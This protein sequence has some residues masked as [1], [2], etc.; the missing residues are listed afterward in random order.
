L[1]SLD[2]NRA[3]IVLISI[4]LSALTCIIDGNIVYRL[5]FVLGSILCLILFYYEKKIWIYVF[6]ALLLLKV[7]YV[8]S[9][10]YITFSFQLFIIKFNVL[11]LILLVIHLN[12][13][14]ILIKDL[15]GN[16]DKT[17]KDNFQ[18]RVQRFEFKYRY[19][20]KKQ[21][22]EIIDNKDVM[23]KEAIQAAS[24]LIDKFDMG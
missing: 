7:L 17:K 19:K 10:F 20:S 18:S 2:W 13:N 23:A 14:E 1:N 6:S 5:P 8:L 16:S 9:P 11:A 24:N 22:N 21:L 3:I 4:G 15:L 12:L